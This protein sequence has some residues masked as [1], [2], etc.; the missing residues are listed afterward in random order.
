MK[1]L[2]YA[3]GWLKVPKE[4]LD[5]ERKEHKLTPDKIGNCLTMYTCTK[6]GYYFKIDSSG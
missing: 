6:C 3:N 2:G 5:C 4:R 1:D